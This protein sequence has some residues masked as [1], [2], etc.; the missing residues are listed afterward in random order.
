MILHLINPYVDRKMDATSG[1]SLKNGAQM[2]KWIFK[3][4]SRNWYNLSCVWM[5]IGRFHT[6]SL[7]IMWI[8]NSSFGRYPGRF[9]WHFFL[10]KVLSNPY[11]WIQKKKV[12]CVTI[13]FQNIWISTLINMLEDSYYYFY[14]LKYV[15][16]NFLNQKNNSC[17]MEEQC[18]FTRFELQ[19]R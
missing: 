19:L 8:R 16:T 3:K 17:D 18:D 6:K 12:L 9:L 5:I 15:V 4:N 2:G 11:F 13:G 1:L 10:W 7:C 14:F